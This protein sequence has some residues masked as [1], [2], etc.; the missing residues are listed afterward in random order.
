MPYFKDKLNNLHFLD[1]AE[2]AH[3]LPPV[4]VQIT[5]AE[6]ADIQVPTIGQV[7]ADLVT[8]I[9]AERDRREAAGFAYLDCVLDSTPRSVQRITAAA[10]AAQAALSAG[11]SFELEWTC[12]NNSALL[13]DAAGVVGM[14]VALAQRA[15]ALHQHARL[16]KQQVLA[17]EN[18]TTL[19]AIDI[20]NGWPGDAVGG[21]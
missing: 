10:F 6:A 13:L 1:N 3:L 21:E 14:P 9:T 8:A 17:A 11:K 19:M 12:A 2:D 15:D 7:K 20:H 5:D 16:L 4:C 18:E